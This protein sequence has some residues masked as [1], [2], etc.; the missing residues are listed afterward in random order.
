V[1]G[2]RR[3]DDEVAGLLALHLRQRGGDAVEHAS[4]VHVD[5]AIPVLDF[6]ALERGMR[7]Q[8][9]VVEHHVDA[10]VG[11][12]R[13]VDQFLH[14]GAVGDVGADRDGLVA[15]FCQLSH[16][17]MQ[18]VGAARAEYDAGTL[19]GQQA[20]GGLAQAAAGA[21]DDDDLALDVRVYEVPLLM[22]DAVEC[23]WRSIN[24]LDG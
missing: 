11:L 19:S 2:H 3:H 21:G 14:L 17:R 22:F 18:A 16:E 13:G 4:E 24:Q 8:A 10:T 12:H 23:R 7:H 15:S 6:Q 5:H 20:C 1:A 9:R